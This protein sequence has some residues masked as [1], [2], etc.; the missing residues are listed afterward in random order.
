MTRTAQER[1]PL[2]RFTSTEVGLVAAFGGMAFAF[3]AMGIVIPIAGS[4][5]WEPKDICTFMAAVLGGPVTGLLVGLIGAI[6]SPW[7]HL[8]GIWALPVVLVGFV[9][10]YFSPRKNAVAYY[11]MQTIAMV[12]WWL[13]ASA[14]WVVL[15]VMP[16][17]VSLVSQGII[18]LSYIPV[19]IFLTEVLRHYSSYL[20]DLIG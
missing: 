7:A 13:L 11:T 19:L 18:S 5:V 15:G 10:R 2:W 8:S 14:A 20:S 4:N 16:L 1:I 12:A 3:K 17:W 9:Q 6:P